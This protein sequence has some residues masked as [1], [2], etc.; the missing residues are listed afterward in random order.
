M[1]LGKNHIQTYIE[2]DFKYSPT[3]CNQCETQVGAL[4]QWHGAFPS[5]DCFTTI[6]VKFTG[7]EF[8]ASFSQSLCVPAHSEFS[9]CFRASNV[10]SIQYALYCCEW[11]WSVIDK[12]RKRWSWLRL[13]SVPE[14]T[15]MLQSKMENQSHEYGSIEFEILWALVRLNRI[16][17]SFCAFFYMKHN[18]II[19]FK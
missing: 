15:T 17:E 19:K 16:T 2:F 8:D 7:L 3:S 6:Q 13:N 1:A 11:I 18:F 9:I 14:R 10:C 5:L 12:K 4:T